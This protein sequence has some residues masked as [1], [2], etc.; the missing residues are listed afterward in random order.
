M[1]LIV[2]RSE[3]FLDLLVEELLAPLHDELHGR[4]PLCHNDTTHYN[5]PSLFE[6]ANLIKFDIKHLIT[7]F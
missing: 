2:E 5:A 1:E 6:I 4:L 3:E 7:G